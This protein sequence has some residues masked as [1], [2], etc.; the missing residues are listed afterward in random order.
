MLVVALARYGKDTLDLGTV[1]RF[2]ERCEAE[3]GTDGCQAQI[4]GSNA[5]GSVGLEVFEEG[6]DEWSVQIVEC[7]VRRRL[8]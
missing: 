5:G 8:V 7:Q 3:E 2:F 4:T 1:G 6:A